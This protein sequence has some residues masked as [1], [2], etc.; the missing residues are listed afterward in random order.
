MIPGDPF[1]AQFQSFAALG[2]SFTEG[3]GDPTADG[4]RLARLGG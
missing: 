1:M 2:D 3:V 4:V